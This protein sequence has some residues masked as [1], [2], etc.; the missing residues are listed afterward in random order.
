MG[1]TIPQ[2]AS[3]HYVLFNGEE[4]VVQAQVMWERTVFYD[5]IMESLEGTFG[6]HLDLADPARRSVAWK[7]GMQDSIAGFTLQSEGVI[8][9]R[10]WIVTKSGRTLAWSP[11]LEFG[12]EYAIF[13]PGGP[14][15]L[16]MAAIA[17][18]HLGSTPGRMMLTP[19]GATDPELGGLA[20]LAF[21]LANEQE[22]L[23]HRAAPPALLNF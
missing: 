15:L 20:V 2:S 23:L 3:R 1:P 11:T 16:S 17:G 5:A 4:A 14:R 9:C 12:Y 6:A 18:V 13:Q 7:V 10:G 21:A 22:M 8:T 19:E